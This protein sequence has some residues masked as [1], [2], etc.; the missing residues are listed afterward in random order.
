[1]PAKVAILAFFSGVE[2]GKTREGVK[3]IALCVILVWCAA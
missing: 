1:M 2:A 3:D